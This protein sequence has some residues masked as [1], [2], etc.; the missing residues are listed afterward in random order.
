MSVEKGG[1]ETLCSIA[2]YKINYLVYFR[3]SLKMLNYNYCRTVR[4][5][6]CFKE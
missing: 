1:P 6:K 5:K 4:G 2:L 3:R